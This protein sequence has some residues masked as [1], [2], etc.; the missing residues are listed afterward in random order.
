[1]K[2]LS[3]RFIVTAGATLLAVVGNAVLAANE[4]PNIVFIMSDD[5]A[6]RAVS[7]YGSKLVE[8]PNIDRIAANGVRFDRAY[9][10]NAISMIQQ[11]P[12]SRK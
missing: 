2:T 4:R 8:T 1:M 3:Y 6:I 7:A 5:H 11:C 10:G 12:P 9:V